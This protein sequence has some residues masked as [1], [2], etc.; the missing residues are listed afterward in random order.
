MEHA[1][2]PLTAAYAVN[3]ATALSHSGRDAD[4]AEFLRRELRNAVDAR[5]VDRAAQL[6]V[7]FAPIM[8][9]LERQSEFDA[10]CERVA[11]LSEADDRT[12]R[13]LRTAR[14][15]TLAFSGRLSEYECIAGDGPATAGDHRCEAFV[16]ALSG[17]DARARRAMQT[18]QAQ[19]ESGDGRQEPADKVLEGLIA[20]HAIGN[21]GLASADAAEH[22]DP[23]QGISH[24]R[25]AARIHDGRWDEGR[26][27]IGR[28]PLWDRTYQEPT[29]ILDMRLE[30]AALAGCAP[31]EIR[32]TR[33]SV[34][35]MIARNQLRHAVTPARWYVIAMQRAGESVD[36]PIEA[37]VA[38][39]L[40]V[41]PI[42]YTLGGTPL[43]VALLKDHFG[44]DRCLAALDRWPRY[45]SRW[46]NAHF[47]LAQALLTNN[48]TQLRHA[49]AEFEVL[50][51]P[52]FAMIAGLAL[53]APRARDV[54]LARSIGYLQK[55]DRTR[56]A[57]TSRE[58]D[59]A[60][61]VAQ[62]LTNRIIAARLGISE[63]TVEVHLTNVY[64][65]LGVRSRSGLARLVDRG[66][67]R[68]PNE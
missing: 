56:P 29:P 57:L 18:Y 24:L 52:V 62:D 2:R 44:A 13:L 60:E 42:P 40:D 66:A 12:R 10:A 32:R 36:A 7:S 49:G 47:A 46:S 37:F 61:L 48:R 14:L 65:K 43:S 58:S 53:P 63:R 5:D 64:R 28:L 51:A 21:L 6:V 16:A 31:A 54:E 11:K 45:G 35:S 34:A 9:T 17:D 50:G 38:E 59:I 23:Y 15:A 68:G 39:S 8:L 67:H 1:D 25:I 3:Y 22:D 26:Q 41:A 19:L 20:L 33:H 27:L 4:A 30:L 55:T